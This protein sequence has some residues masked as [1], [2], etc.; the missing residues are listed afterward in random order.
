MDRPVS[1]LLAFD[2]NFHEKKF[3]TNILKAIGHKFCKKLTIC[4]QIVHLSLY[5][6]V[7]FFSKC[8]FDKYL[9]VN[10][11]TPVV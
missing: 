9:L 4:C 8:Y 10:G 6:L 2:H 11:V 7:D 5:S 3:E 1:L